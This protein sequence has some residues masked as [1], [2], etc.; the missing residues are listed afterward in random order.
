LGKV[1][2]EFAVEAVDAVVLRR[3]FEGCDS[4]SER[5]MNVERPHE[6]LPLAQSPREPKQPVDRRHRLIEP[7]E[8]HAV[9]VL[10][11]ELDVHVDRVSCVLQSRGEVIDAEPARHPVDQRTDLFA[12]IDHPTAEHG[13]H[14]S[15][16]LPPLHDLDG[17]FFAGFAPSFDD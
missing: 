8:S 13:A 5:D 16:V 2:A 14:G 6:R 11:V 17:S 3:G 7:E 9:V 10:A 12:R 15:M 4:A 1:Q